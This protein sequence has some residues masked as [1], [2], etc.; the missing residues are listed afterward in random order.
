MCV[1][2]RVAPMCMVVMRVVSFRV[3]SC[4]VFVNVVFECMSLCV[5]LCVFCLV[6]SMGCRVCS[7]PVTC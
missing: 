5:V 6:V 1:L 4:S 3:C 2:L 7:S